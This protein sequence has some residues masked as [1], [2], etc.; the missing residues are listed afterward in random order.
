MNFP[1]ELFTRSLEN[2]VLIGTPPCKFLVLFHFLDFRVERIHVE[3]VNVW[4]QVLIKSD[5]SV[6]RS[7]DLLVFDK[8]ACNEVEEVHSAGKTTD[9]RFSEEVFSKDKSFFGSL[10]EF[11]GF[12]K[13][14]E[15][16]S[17]RLLGSL[18]FVVKH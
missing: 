3:L 18:L 1:L 15:V 11:K 2:Q 6:N 12:V 13:L 5:H 8:R 9:H 10:R 14:N 17:V 4:H 7:L 16:D